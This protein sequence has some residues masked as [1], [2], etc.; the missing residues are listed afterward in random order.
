MLGAHGAVFCPALM[1]QGTAFGAVFTAQLTAFAVNFA[2]FHTA[3]LAHVAMGLV[4]GFGA[5]HAGS[6]SRSGHLG[7]AGSAQGR[8]DGSTC[9]SEEFLYLT[10]SK[11]SKPQTL[12]WGNCLDALCD[13]NS[14][15]K[16]RACA[17]NVRYLS[18]CVDNVTWPK[19][20]P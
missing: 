13:R 16:P 6:G 3:L 18:L 4:G 12:R 7:K 1:A 17:T 5:G 10:F 14:P 9:D 19:S 20:G 15:K 8:H 11:S 2:A